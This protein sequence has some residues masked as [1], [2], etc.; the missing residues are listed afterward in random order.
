MIL[1]LR[2]DPP[3]GIGLGCWTQRK[4]KTSVVSCLCVVAVRRIFL[5]AASGNPPRAKD[6]LSARFWLR[7]RRAVRELRPE[8]RAG[9]LRPARLRAPWEVRRDEA[10]LQ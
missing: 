6:G 4:L 2:A 9:P 10:Q 1:V 5:Q 3:H 7:L 8:R